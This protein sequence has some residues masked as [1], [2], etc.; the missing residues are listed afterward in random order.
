MALQG[1]RLAEPLQVRPFESSWQCAETIYRED[2][3]AGFY[4]G[5]WPYM[6]SM[7]VPVSLAQN[8]CVGVFYAYNAFT[9][10]RE[11]RR[12]EAA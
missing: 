8:A 5:F 1:S 7:V 2:G 6:F 11:K 3:L 4:R 9:D 12:A 10:R